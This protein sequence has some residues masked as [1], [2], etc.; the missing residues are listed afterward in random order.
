MWTH[1][2]GTFPLTRTL[3]LSKKRSSPPTCSYDACS[4]LTSYAEPEGY[5]FS[6]A[7]D[8]SGA[9]RKDRFSTA[10]RPAYPDGPHFQAH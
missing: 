4:R 1:P 5:A 10:S 6:F 7:Y 9:A 3:R 8:G 2:E